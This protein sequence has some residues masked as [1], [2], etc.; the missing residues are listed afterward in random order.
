MMSLRLQ[1]ALVFVVS[2][3]LFDALHYLLHRWGQLAEPAAAHL[4]VLALGAPRFLD[5][6]MRIHPDLAGKY[7]GFTSC[8]ST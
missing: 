2:T 4:L 1:A 3:L 6:K 7:S 8:P 5:R